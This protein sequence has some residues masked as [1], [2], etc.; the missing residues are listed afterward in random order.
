MEAQLREGP[1]WWPKVPSRTTLACAAPTTVQEAVSKIVWVADE[2][3]DLTQEVVALALAASSGDEIEAEVAS[4]NVDLAVQWHRQEELY[5]KGY[6]RHDPAPGVHHLSSVAINKQYKAQLALCILAYRLRYHGATKGWVKLV[7]SQAQVRYLRRQAAALR[8]YV[9]GLGPTLRWRA[10]R[11]PNGVEAP[12]PPPPRGARALPPVLPITPAAAR[13]LE[14]PRRR[15]R[16]VA[17]TASRRPRQR[18]EHIY[19]SMDS[20]SRTWSFLRASSSRCN[21][22]AEYHLK[23][24]L[25]DHLSS[26]T[27]G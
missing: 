16:G 10:E 3:P 13:T 8:A 20:E 1:I 4:L 6:W 27:E 24:S 11:V 18:E 14:R 2:C 15:R 25:T 21:R 9:E 22:S 5:R 17:S 12:P 23:I 19:I 7:R 26:V